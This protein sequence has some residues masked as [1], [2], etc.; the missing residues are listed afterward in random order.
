MQ[1]KHYVLFLSIT[2]ALGGFLFGFDTAVIS[3]AERDI[4]ALWQ[5]SDLKH[6]LAVAVALYGTVL[7]ALFGGIPA[8]RWGR[9]TSLLWIGLFYFVSALGSALA[10]DVNSFML[11]RFLGGLGVG[12]SSVV[13]PM[14]I[15]EI[16]PAARRGQLVALYQFNIVFGILMA[17]FSNYLIGTANLNEAWRWMMGVEAIPALIYTV[18]IFKVP[19]SPRWLIAKRR[20]FEGA[21]EILTKTDPEGVDEA[22][23]LAIEES[24]IIKGKA[25]VGMLFNSKFR[26]ISIMA[27]LMAFFNQVSGINAIIYFAPRVFESAGIAS[28]TALMSTIGIGVINLVTTMLGLYLIDKFGRKLLMYIGSIGYIVSLS[29]MAYSYFGGAI[30]SSLLPYFVFVF[31]A[32]HAIGQGSVIWVFI[33]EIFPNELRAFGQSMGSFT[34]WILAALIANIFP[35]IANQYGAGNIFAFFAVMMVL[36]LLWVAW[37]MP[38]TKGRSLEELQRELLGKNG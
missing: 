16:A 34:H 28:E 21:R 35:L 3:G 12:A 32:S 36:Q 26:K 9:K 2:A 37:K 25:S 31:I 14:Y 29:L 24:K 15:S 19:K 4:Q 18:L 30:D 38:E 13:A 22:I 17:Y 6:G 5:L 23:A 10:A 7:G 1:N 33:S 11:F 8:D 27:V 20:D